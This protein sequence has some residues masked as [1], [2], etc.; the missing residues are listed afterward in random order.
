MASV[1]EIWQR[2]ESTGISDG[3]SGLIPEISLPST[4]SLAFD[5]IS[6]DVLVV[7]CR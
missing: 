7:N 4:L 2:V 1:K 6:I 5:F 3:T